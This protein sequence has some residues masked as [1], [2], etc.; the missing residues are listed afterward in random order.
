MEEI[1]LKE[2]VFKIKGKSPLIVNNI[3]S[4]RFFGH[5]ANGVFAPTIWN[6]TDY[7]VINIIMTT[8]M[9]QDLGWKEYQRIEKLSH[10]EQAVWFREQWDKAV[11]VFENDP[12]RVA[13][14]RKAYRIQL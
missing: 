11:S 4:S 2:V 7:D 14:I 9:S 10:K 3:E 8:K 12:R 13:R 5:H 1:G 6:M